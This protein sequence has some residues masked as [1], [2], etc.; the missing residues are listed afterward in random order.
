VK[1]KTLM[2][3]ALAFI[4]AAFL[5]G[6]FV[7]FAHAADKKEKTKPA[8]AKTIDSGSFGIFIK[9]Q[10]VATETFRIEQLNGV[11]IIKSQLKEM[12]GGD[13]T[14]QKSDL[15]MTANSELL[16][17]E[18]SQA[19]GGSLSVFPENE[20]IK[21]RITTSATAKPAEQAFLLP[22]SAPILD[23]NFFV[24]REVLAWKY[25]Q[26]APCKDEN[27]QRRCQPSDFGAF[28]PQDHMSM[29]VRMA[30]VGKEKITV[31]GTE[32]ELLRLNL[33]GEGFDWA[34]WLDEHDSYKLV[35]VAIPANNSEVVRD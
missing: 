20:F 26:I 25:L 23:N 10:R 7:G 6:L 5:P 12:A 18:W 35:K 31:R 28:V 21:E 14:G 17:Y 13:S 11:T 19:S 9:G 24:Q 16:R 27:G 30:L 34:L 8:A 33:T 2:R 22:T 15:E 29:P 1:F 3:R 4:L 32:R